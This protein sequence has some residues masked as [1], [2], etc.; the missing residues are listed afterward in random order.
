MNGAASIPLYDLDMLAPGMAN[1]LGDWAKFKSLLKD[2]GD[3]LAL[4]WILIFVFRCEADLCTV[5]AAAIKAGPTMAIMVGRQIYDYHQQLYMMSVK[6]H[7]SE[8]VSTEDSS[9]ESAPMEEEILTAGSKAILYF[10][11]SRRWKFRL[12][13]YHLLGIGARQPWVSFLKQFLWLLLMFMNVFKLFCIFYLD[14]S[15]SYAI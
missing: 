13:D 1:M 12:K 8:N 4:C 9:R 3:F 15:Y 2:C 10:Y 11:H 7:L 6:Q 5:A 14:R